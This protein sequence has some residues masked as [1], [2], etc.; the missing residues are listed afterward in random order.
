MRTVR[1]IPLMWPFV[2]WRALLFSRIRLVSLRRRRAV[3]IDRARHLGRRRPDGRVWSPPGRMGSTISMFGVT[4]TTGRYNFP[5][6]K[7]APPPA[8]TALI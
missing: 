6:R 2:D 5:K 1:G 4:D 8:S 3:A 7:L